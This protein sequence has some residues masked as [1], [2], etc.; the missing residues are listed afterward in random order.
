MEGDKAKSGCFVTTKF[1]AFL[2]ILFVALTLGVGL[3][4]YFA[5]KNGSDDAQTSCVNVPGDAD[6]LWERCIE[7]ADQRDDC[8][9]L[10]VCCNC[11]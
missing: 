5:S 4:V 10:I 2:C 9:Y 6:A 8:M 7:A 1:A 3:I 11:K